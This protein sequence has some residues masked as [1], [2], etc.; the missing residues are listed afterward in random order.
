MYEGEPP[1]IGASDQ[2]SS[3]YLPIAEAARD[4]TIAMTGGAIVVPE[5]QAFRMVANDHRGN[6][7]PISSRRIV[8]FSRRQ[9]HRDSSSNIKTMQQQERELVSQPVSREQNNQNG[10]KPLSVPRYA[11]RQ[12]RVGLHPNYL[13]TCKTLKWE[14]CF[15]LWNH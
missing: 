4:G 10:M 3:E 7:R 15:G 5:R 8:P 11:H 9:Q 1:P 13:E 12:S 2:K 6:H 14:L